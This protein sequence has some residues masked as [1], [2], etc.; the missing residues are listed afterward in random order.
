MGFLLFAVAAVLLVVAGRYR[1]GVRRKRS[2]SPDDRSLTPVLVTAAVLSGALSFLSLTGVFQADGRHA[3]NNA[4]AAVPGTPDNPFIGTQGNDDP[5]FG[6]VKSWQDLQAA[7]DSQPWYQECLASQ[8]G[9]TWTQVQQ[10]A[11]VEKSGGV[12]DQKIISENSTIS[13]A[14]MLAGLRGQGYNL[15]D[16]TPVDYVTV[17]ENT[18]GLGSEKCS[19]FQDHRSQVRVALVVP[20][21]TQAL[22]AAEHPLVLEMCSNPLRIPT[23][24]TTQPPDTTETTVPGSSVPSTTVPSTTTT[25]PRQITVCRPG[26]GIITIPENGRKPGDTDDLSKCVPPVT[27]APEPTTTAPPSTTTTTMAGA[28]S[29]AGGNTGESPPTTEGPPATAPPTTQPGGGIHQH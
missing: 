23:T 20:Q 21:P 27:V 19:P 11:A 15:P 2:K 14:D 9:T 10:Y 5:V 22:V 8:N 1:V 6:S 3:S 7:G 29:P 28:S 25:L 24:P 26:V 4:A 12:F 17:L 16:D 13:K 18:R